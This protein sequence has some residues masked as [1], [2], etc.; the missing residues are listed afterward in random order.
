M[1]SPY[2]HLFAGLATTIGVILYL[3]IRPAV[4]AGTVAHVEN[5]FQF[6]VYAPFEKVAPLF[7]AFEERA[8]A[9]EKW[10]PLFLYPR[11]PRDVQGE[12][13]LVEHGH[14]H[15]TAIWINTAFD[16]QSGHLQ[17]A[18]VVPEMQAVLIDIHLSRHDA[19]VSTDVDVV[20]QRTALKPELNE[21]ITEIGHKDRQNAPEWSS[22]IERY[23]AVNSH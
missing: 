3:H 2:L 12:V 1:R 9:G 7:G 8:W 15:A 21:H 6:T 18:Y 20:Y 19:P 10:N 16:L 5:K 14:G 4:A 22:A 23:L 11:P 17:Y 13:F